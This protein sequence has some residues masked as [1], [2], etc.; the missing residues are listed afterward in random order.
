MSAQ[1]FTPRPQPAFQPAVAEEQ[2]RQTIGYS[3]P[4]RGI[5][6]GTLLG[7]TALLGVSAAWLSRSGRLEWLGLAT[8]LAAAIAAGILMSTGMNARSE[9]SDTTSVVQLVQA[10]PGTNDIRVN[11]VTGVFSPGIFSPGQESTATLSGQSGGWMI[12]ETSGIEGVARRLIWSDIDQWA[13]ENIPQKPGLR[14][15]LSQVSGR[16][17]IP[18]VAK[19]GFMPTGLTGRIQ[20]PDGLSPAD[21]ILATSDGR[22]GLTITND[23]QWTAGN[24]SEL[25]ANQ[26]LAANVLSDEQQRRNRVLSDLLKPVPNK[27]VPKV[28]TL[29]VWTK[30]WNAGLSFGDKAPV[31]GSALVAIPVDWIPPAP[32]SEF[33]VPRPLLTYSEVTG[34][35][36]I[37]PSGF[38]DARTNE[39]R[40]R[41]GATGSWIAFDLPASILPL[42]TKS[43][44]VTFKVKGAMGRLE[45]SG[46][47]DGK[48][49]SIKTW[50][51]PVGT[52][53]HTIDDGTLLPLDRNGRF[54]IRIDAGLANT[55]AMTNQTP[56]ATEQIPALEA[57]T[58]PPSDASDSSAIPAPVLSTS[59]L[60]NFW[61]FEEISARI[62]VVAPLSEPASPTPP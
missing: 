3:I 33:T 18:L 51:D 11:G 61:Q 9:V 6:L 46:F 50:D 49:H 55:Q 30:P 22:I 48:V 44:D 4:S 15:I 19:V 16:A 39:W 14:T 21:A 26:Y 31:T 52:L 25:R 20:I 62:T 47:K 24:D 36:G 5:I 13:W 40:E 34:P 12:P 53:T 35:D 27:Q 54:L 59:N 7:F 37:R 8:P 23:G 42:T 43:V 45:I 57:T 60:T 56:A 28:P 2:V 29:Y 1:F 17:P 58:P 32:G 10:V 41:T 38:Y